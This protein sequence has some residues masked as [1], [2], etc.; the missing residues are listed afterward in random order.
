MRPCPP[1]DIALPDLAA[2][3]VTPNTCKITNG[4]VTWEALPGDPASNGKPENGCC[5]YDPQ[6]KTFT[7]PVRLNQLTGYGAFGATP[8]GSFE[9]TLW[10]V[11]FGTGFIP[12][13]NGKVHV[14]NTV[15]AGGTPTWQMATLGTTT[16]RMLAQKPTAGNYGMGNVYP[17]RAIL[18]W[19]WAVPSMS[20]TSTRCN[21]FP[22]W[23]NVANF[24]IR[25]DP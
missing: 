16:E 22:V 13:A 18:T 14:T 25:L 20:P 19:G 7:C 8:L 5:G 15:A 17:A 9:H 3:A 10:C 11:D 23:G 2:A 6:S 21:Y 12:V 1:S 4:N 24:M